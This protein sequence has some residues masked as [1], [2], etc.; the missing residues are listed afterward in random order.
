MSL[1]ASSRISQN[2]DQVLET[3]LRIPNAIEQAERCVSLVPNDRLLFDRT[4]KV[5][6]AALAAIEGTVKWLRGSP[7]SESYPVTCGQISE[8]YE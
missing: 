5:F 1:Q 6:I 4:L 3:L 2:R 8:F 7:T